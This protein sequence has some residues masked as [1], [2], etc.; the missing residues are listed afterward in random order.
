VRT[1]LAVA[2][3]LTLAACGQEDLPLDDEEPT[4]EDDGKADDGGDELGPNEGCPFTTP[5]PRKQAVFAVPAGVPDLT[6][7][8]EFRRLLRAAVPGSTVR[9][10]IYG[11]SRHIVASE[12]IAAGQRGVDIRV[13]VDGLNRFEQPKGSG[14]YVPFSALQEIRTALGDDAVVICSDD[15]VPPVHLKGGCL[16]SGINHN[17]FAVFSELCDGSHDVVYQSSSNFSAQQNEAQQ[18]AVILRDDQILHDAYLQYWN[19]EAAKIPIPNYYREINSRAFFFP[20]PRTGTN[21]REPSTDTVQSILDN[22]SCT[23]GT[24]IRV[25]MAYW[26][27]SRDY[28]VDTLR[29]LRDAGCDVRILGNIEITSDG[30]KTKLAASF[31]PSEFQLLPH[32]HHKYFF[33][34]GTYLSTQRKLVWTGSHNWDFGAI[35]TNDEA[36][37]RVEDPQVFAAFDANW[38]RMWATGNP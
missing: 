21:L 31:S 20:R 33:V 36:I 34:D 25:A 4:A 9:I 37:L 13:V 38:D 19:D 28:L 16:S 30:V 7:E 35:R 11:F 22:V 12:V 24:R 15:E 18:N 8:N 6:V 5:T 26:N 29:A 23:N 10:S 2:V 3:V 1:S 17:K 32:I 27:D 14:I